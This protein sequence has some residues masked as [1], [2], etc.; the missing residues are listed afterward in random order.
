MD[1]YSDLLS[2]C[3]PGGNS[4]L[5]FFGM[6][7]ESIQYCFARNSAN[8]GC[9]VQL[10]CDRVEF[11]VSNDYRARSRSPS[12]RLSGRLKRRRIDYSEVSDTDIDL[13]AKSGYYD[14]A[15]L[16]SDSEQESG[17]RSGEQSET[18]EISSQEDSVPDAHVKAPVK[19]RS[20]P[21]VPAFTEV[22]LIFPLNQPEE[23]KLAVLFA[24]LSQV[25]QLPTLVYDSCEE[26]RYCLAAAAIDWV[27]VSIVA[28][29][30]APSDLEG[31]YAPEDCRQLYESDGNAEIRRKALPEP[32]W[33]RLR[34]A[35]SF[36][37][38]QPQ[39]GRPFGLDDLPNT[40]RR[41]LGAASRASSS[42]FLANCKD[43]RD[44]EGHEIVCFH[45][46][47]TSREPCKR[48]AE[49]G[50]DRDR[51]CGGSWRR[52]KHRRCKTE[53]EADVEDNESSEHG[54]ESAEKDEDSESW[55]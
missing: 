29:G 35:S 25:A 34:G 48:C 54:G 41:V 33:E 8:N 50:D 17:L 5:R 4:R 27:L 20:T 16:H 37:G 42:E 10:V 46:P 3:T 31:L 39:E 36:E 9:F 47:S 14:K 28:E 38:K 43:A 49:M 1:K 55:D 18:V 13:Q 53:D 2:L 24:A 11:V 51:G 19:V 21:L 6:S 26:A 22:D 12:L 23:L 15:D 45:P 32:N 30:L 40:N 52:P 44:D 7:Y